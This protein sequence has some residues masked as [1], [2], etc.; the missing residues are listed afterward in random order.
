MAEDKNKY[1][2]SIQG[3]SKSFGRN[4]VLNHIN[5]NVKP[6]SIMGL[7]GENGAGKSTMMKCLFGTYQKDEGT[8]VLDGKEVNFSGPKDA[9]ENGVAMVHQELNQC[10]ERNVIDNLFLGRYPKNSLGVVDEGRMKKEASDLFR[11]LGITV[12]LTQPMKKMS[13]SKRQMCEIA[14]A[15]SYN[16]KVIVLDE[17]TSSLTAPE[18]AKLFKMMRQL[19]S[20]GISLIYISHKMDEIFE[21]C[22]QISVLRDGSLVMTKD[23]KDT[24]M[25]E[26]IS[27]MVGRSLDNRFPPVD[28]TPGE[29]ILS[30]QNLSTKYAPK[31]QNISFD[32]K[33]GEIFGLYG[34]VGAGR[35]ELLETIFGMRTRAAGN[36]IYD[37]KMMNFA[38]PKDA[39]NHGFALITEERKANGLFLKADITFNTT[40]ANMNHYK[41]GLALSHD[42]MVR[43]TAE[44][45]KVMHTKC[46]GPDDMIA[47]LSGGN[48]QKVIFGKWLERSPNIF[49]MDDPT[50][51]IDVG[52]KYEIY[53]LII[54]MAKQ[55]KTI[56]VVS[57]EMPEILGITNRIGVMS[58]GHL[59][60]IVN[61]KETNQEELLK[62]S[63]K[64]L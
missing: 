60:G 43:A 23:S 46:M 37:G 51:G 63:A 13:V 16:S 11:K 28:N 54:N 5:L 55:G 12:N 2:L 31:L 25:N 47:N 20:Q 3:M 14:K 33:K 34:L 17:P 45:I 42:D 57:S 56:I 48:Q 7:M 26:L 6:G 35:T 61:T 58:N 38:S 27:A 8:I 53:E 40:I 1:I 22:D 29:T 50:R 62:L 39:M 44:E 19:K 32:V 52:A 59:A 24:N 4:K 10:L 30:V 49:M 64:Y 15:I 41:S 21:I 18:V 9:L 36:V